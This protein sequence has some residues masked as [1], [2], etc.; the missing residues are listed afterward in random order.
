M[1]MLHKTNLSLSALLKPLKAKKAQ[2]LTLCAFFE[3]FGTGLFS[4]W[5]SCWFNCAC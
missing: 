4:A 3:E 2:S 1:L 5:C